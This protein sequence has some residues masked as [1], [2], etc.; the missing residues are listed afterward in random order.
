MD[1]PRSAASGTEPKRARGR[2]RFGLRGMIGAVL[3]LGLAFAWLARDDRS[4]FERLQDDW[5][6][7][8]NAYWEAMRAAKTPEAKRRV[9]AELSP[10]PAAFA[11]R[12]LTLARAMPGTPSELAAL[13]WAANNASEA[14]SGKEALAILEAGRLERAGPG[15]LMAA[16][17]RVRASDGDQAHSLA[18]LVL[19]VARRNLDRP[20]AAGLLTWV[21][22][23]QYGDRSAR[24]P[25]T[26]AEA[27]D[28]IAGRFAASPDISHFGE[29]L[30]GLGTGPPW[31]PRYE[32]HL[33][34]ILDRNRTRLVR[35]TASFALA[36][37]AQG[38]GE[39]G[40]DRA[41]ALYRQFLRDFDGSDPS[42]KPV[43]DNLIYQAKAEAE[44][45]RS[46]GLGKPA[47]EVV[48]VDLDGRPLS[49]DEY[50]GKVVLVSFWATWCAPCMALIPHE[51]ALLDRF[52]GRP[53]AIVGV[54]GDRDPEERK[55]ALAKVEI[56]R[57]SFRD[58]RPGLPF[59]S[60]EWKVSGWP[61]LF[62]IDREGVIRNRWVGAPEGDV[63]DREIARLLDPPAPA[64][65]SK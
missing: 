28:L 43:E 57:H 24:E 56:P 50:R 61:T 4:P 26:F 51:R 10:K 8:E 35:C 31:A 7:Q 27:A 58:E 29:A 16:L 62:L 18:P 5:S 37:M 9:T 46:R 13:C 44:G 11:G 63:L 36:S 64:G 45:I 53:F 52:R 40:Q 21:C 54:N 2:F 34:T 49:L 20:E 12:C 42:I 19:G 30:G 17:E 22:A 33:R 1:E 60:E 14:D 3:V 32:K 65:A 47:P 25:S 6:R 48:G 39:A 59:L 55:Q 41:E 38:A 23:C 15:V